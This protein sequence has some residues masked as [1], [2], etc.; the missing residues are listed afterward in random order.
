MNSK[1]RNK[2]RLMAARLHYGSHT[3]SECGQKGLHWVGIPY[4]LQDVIDKKEPEGFWTC[5]K[6]YGANGQRLQEQP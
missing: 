3:C 6:F 5:D 1:Q 2:N 4:T